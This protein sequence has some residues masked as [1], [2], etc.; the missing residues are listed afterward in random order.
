MNT[1]LAIVAYQSA[2]KPLACWGYGEIQNTE[3]L[4]LAPSDY[5][6]GCDCDYKPHAD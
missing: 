2:G 5:G 1:W 6:L 3:F 4:C